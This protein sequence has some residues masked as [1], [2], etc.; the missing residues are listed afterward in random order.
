VG[1]IHCSGLAANYSRCKRPIDRREDQR[2]QIEEPV[3]DAPQSNWSIADGGVT[4]GTLTPMTT[5]YWPP[6]CI[7]VTT[8]GTFSTTAV[9]AF[10]S[11]LSLSRGQV[12]QSA[13]PAMFFA[14]SPQQD[15]PGQRVVPS[16]PCQNSLSLFWAQKGPKSTRCFSGLA[17]CDE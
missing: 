14:A 3:E 2:D 13:A 12:A 8:P 16:C 11:S 5:C 15:I 1:V 10:D 4:V 17:S 9:S 6:A 7:T